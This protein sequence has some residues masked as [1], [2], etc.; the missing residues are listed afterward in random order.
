MCSNCDGVTTRSYTKYFP[1][2]AGRR[3]HEVSPDALF[4]VNA[5]GI[6]TIGLEGLCAID[7][8]SGE[9]GYMP[10]GHLQ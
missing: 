6:Q 5:T 2:T 9:E 3:F 1:L 4:V 7:V 8:G 10:F